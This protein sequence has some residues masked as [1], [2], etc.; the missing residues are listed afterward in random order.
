M[1]IKAIL[2]DHDGTIVDSEK[3]HFEMWR[4]VLIVYDIEL[5]YEEYTNQYAGIPT[6]TN[7]I[8]ITENYS[9][10]ATP[11][12]LVKAKNEQSKQYLLKQAFPLMKGAIDS[13][14]Y[15]HKQGY[16]IGIVTGAGREGVAVSL[17]EHGL[18][19]YVSVCVSG[20]DVVNSKPAPDCYLL[21]AEKL[22]FQPSECLAIEDTY[23][24]SLAA[25]GAGIKCIGVSGS[26]RV[27]DL[28]TQTIYEC[29]DLNMATKW[30]F[31]TFE[32]Q[33]K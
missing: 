11:F 19:K 12:E 5:S 14:R 3:A 4:N 23:N 16:K 33:K 31:E 1:I 13:I 9:I 17:V 24:G 20:D 2:F 15:F 7:A 27:R 32:I 30:I 29:T 21:A 26:D 25:I 22:G 6:T 28:F 8:T 10:D 18:E